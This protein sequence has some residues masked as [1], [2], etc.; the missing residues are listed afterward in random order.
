MEVGGKRTVRSCP[1]WHTL[2]L[3]CAAAGGCERHLTCG[4]FFWYWWS[5]QEN[6]W[7]CKKDKS[8]K[9]IKRTPDLGEAFP[10]YHQH[11]CYVSQAGVLRGCWG[12]SFSCNQM[13][14]VMGSAVFQQCHPGMNRSA[15]ATS[16]CT[17]GCQEEIS[18]SASL[19]T[20][21]CYWASLWSLP[22]LQNCTVGGKLIS[23]GQP[24]TYAESTGEKIGDPVLILR[25]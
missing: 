22:P 1:H 7:G 4:D 25:A 15:G 2:M 8:G 3:N 10:G 13:H 16:L 23:G 14:L 19:V 20:T 9:I 18:A 21:S 6:T 5:R 12:W 11:Q 17:L 24:S